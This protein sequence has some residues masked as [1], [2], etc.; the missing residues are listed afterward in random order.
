MNKHHN[1]NRVG[2]GMKPRGNNPGQAKAAAET[3]SAVSADAGQQQAPQDPQN[4]PSEQAPSGSS[5]EVQNSDSGEAASVSPEAE[6]ADLMAKSQRPK[7]Q[8][9][10]GLTSIQDIVE[11]A[12]GIGKRPDGTFGMLVTIPEG[13]LDP[14]KE[15]A[16]SDGVSPEEWMSTRVV[17]LLENFWSPARSR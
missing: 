8:E 10:G 15:Q 2:L 1:K 11:E 6:L 13:Y 9:Q 14:V 3:E 4:M 7:E 16:A 5:L 12:A 17:E